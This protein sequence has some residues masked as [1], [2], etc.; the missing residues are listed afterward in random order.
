MAFVPGR[1]LSAVL[2]LFMVVPNLSNG[3]PIQDK[4]ALLD[5]L[6]KV[7]HSNRL[8]WNASASACEW[9][10]VGCDSSRTY[11]SAL[12]LPG[13]G[14]VAEIPAGTIGR[15]SQ[16]RVLSLRSNGLY[17]EIPNDFS[18]LT[19]LRS[20]YLQDNQF[21]G[22]FPQS[23]A[24]LTR[25]VRLDLSSNNFSGVIPFGI[26]NLTHLSRLYLQDNSFSGELPSIDAADTG[27]SLS[28]F[29]VSNN[30][31][32]GSIPKSLARFP[33]S[34]FTGNLQLCGGKLAPCK[35][36]FFPPPAAPVSPSSVVPSSPA[37]RHR[38]KLSAAGIAGIAVASAV[39]FFIL[40]FCLVSCLVR[41]QRQKLTKSPKRPPF[42]SSTAAV[43]SAVGG[44]DAGT[45]S[46]K[47]DLTSGAAA[48][49]RNKLVF[50][51]AGGGR[52]NFD[53]EDLLRASAEVLGKGS[54]GTTYKA[55]L[56]EGITVVVKRLKDVTAAKREFEMQME[57]LGGCS[58]EN[59]VPLRA[60]Y[61]SKDEKLLVYDYYRAGS[62]S[63]LLHGNRGSGKTSLDWDGRMRMALGTARGLTYLHMSN[64]VVHGN[65]KSSN[66]LLQQD[67]QD[68]FI[69]DFGIA[70]L[71]GNSIQ[72][73]KVAGYRA[74]EV[75][76]ARKVSF[77]SDVYS[78]GVL[79]LE[80]LTGKAPHQASFGEE[81]I[82]LPRWV[83]SVVQ[84]EWTAEV[85]DVELIRY[86]NV[87]D[88]MVNLLQIAIS[89][90]QMMPDQRPTMPE[91]FRMI[92]G[93]NRGEA[94]N[95]LTEAKMAAAQILSV[96]REYNMDDEQRM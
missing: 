56:E 83:Q 96:Y 49:E 78:F 73:N 9:V 90:V 40:L 23:L 77:K 43:A 57:V 70:T 71:F 11:V 68:A 75:L 3:E 63:A 13:A 84:E 22:G 21:S 25:L 34:S 32:N 92:E 14:L 37:E 2:L 58:H 18:N 79:L 72:Y 93:I 27:G 55:V 76:E 87:E 54:V 74:P 5:F 16:L 15:L 50:L 20:L 47:D 51:S 41:R 94:N 8:D 69:S 91:V 7:P 86:N 48:G 6:N 67:H 60:Y 95:G 52:H 46:S 64:N 26:N 45:S 28:D 65:I 19:L 12:R 82:D 35:G 66:I 81:G 89:C 4:Q 31:L 80:L 36:S 62:L 24:Q 44:G 88:E 30:N 85:F 42:S 33:E 1:L 17:G 53:L 39:C 38:K 61:Y 10:G 59:L 29:N